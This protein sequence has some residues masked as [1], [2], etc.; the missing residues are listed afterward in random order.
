MISPPVARVQT[1]PPRVTERGGRADVVPPYTELLQWRLAQAPSP[2]TPRRN[3]FVFGSRPRVTA[4]V[5]D[6]R[7]ATIGTTTIPAGPVTLPE[8]EGPSV[9]LLGIGSKTTPNGVVRT[10]VISDGDTVHLVKGG[11]VIVGFVVVDVTEDSATLQNAAGARWQL[12]LR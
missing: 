10:A 2:P 8:P 12:R 6:E 1:L 7:Q 4:P 11:D 3:P 9:Q 5:A